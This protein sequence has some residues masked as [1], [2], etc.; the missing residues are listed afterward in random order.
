MGPSAPRRETWLQLHKQKADRYPMAMPLSLWKR[1]VVVGALVG[2]SAA[3][4][5]SESRDTPNQVWFTT[6]QVPEV[7]LSL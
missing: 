4:L 1:I 3:R 5:P 2:S 7:G 6:A